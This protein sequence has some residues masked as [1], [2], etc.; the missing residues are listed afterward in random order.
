MPSFF[1]VF[2]FMFPA[3]PFEIYTLSHFDV[4]YV[5]GSIFYAS[6]CLSMLV[7]KF[8]IVLCLNL[9]FNCYSSEKLSASLCFA[10]DV[11]AGA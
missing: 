7:F 6:C 4:D 2:A 11:N 8:K 9:I 10:S 1:T 3:I 5:Y